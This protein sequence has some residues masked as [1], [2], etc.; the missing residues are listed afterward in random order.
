MQ[1]LG[2]CTVRMFFIHKIINVSMTFLRIAG[3]RHFHMEELTRCSDQCKG[4]QFT[5][6]NVCAQC[7]LYEHLCGKTC[8]FLLLT[9]R[10]YLSNVSP[11]LGF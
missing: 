6:R 4:R 2:A 11:H 7:S 1:V 5:V 3:V 8:I 10:I 9:C